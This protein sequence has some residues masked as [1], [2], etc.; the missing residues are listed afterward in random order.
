QIQQYKQ[1]YELNE[2]PAPLINDNDVLVKTGAAG[3]CHTDYQVW[4]GVYESPCPIVPSHEPVGTIVAVGSVAQAK[5][6]VGQR[7]GVLLFRHACKTCI[8]CETTNDIRFCGSAN[9]AG[10]KGDGGFAE[11]IVG[12][13]DNLCLLPEDIQFEQGAP[14]MCAGATVW[15]AIQSGKVAPGASIGVIGIGGLGSLAVQFAKA[16]GHPVVAIDNRLEGRDLATEF[17]LKADLVLDSQDPEAVFKAKT[18]A[19]KGGLSAIIVCTDDVPVIEW[20]LNLLRPNGVCVPLGLPVSSLQF[21]SFTLIFQQI[22]VVG[23]LVATQAEAQKMLDTA[24]KF[25]IRSHV[26]VIPIEKAVDLPDLYMDKHLKG[27]L[28]VRF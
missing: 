2:I 12:D 8:N 13:A 9:L 19:G 15:G 22:T 21:N 23:S 26:T 6:K 17:P 5:W 7:V 28:V 4:E 16:L 3:F 18:Y 25:G 14:L 24:A 20:S 27:R 10:L 1:K 11:Y